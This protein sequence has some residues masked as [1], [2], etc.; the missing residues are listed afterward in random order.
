MSHLSKSWSILYPRW[1]N[2]TGGEQLFILLPLQHPVSAVSM[3][4]TETCFSHRM[5]IHSLLTL[6]LLW[7]ASADSL[8]RKVDKSKV[9]KLFQISL[10]CSHDWLV[11]RNILFYIDSYFL[12]SSEDICMCKCGFS[13][14]VDKSKVVP[15]SCKSGHFSPSPQAFHVPLIVW[16]VGVYFHPLEWVLLRYFTPHWCAQVLCYTLSRLWWIGGYYSLKWM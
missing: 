13:F 1:K 5:A 9:V 12:W 14:V 4:T 7:T 15:L 8:Q 6:H 2:R 3:C 11:C 16:W 10:F